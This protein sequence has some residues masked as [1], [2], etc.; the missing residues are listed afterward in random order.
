M[1]MVHFAFIEIAVTNRTYFCEMKIACILYRRVFNL[2]LL[3]SVRRQPV[4]TRVNDRSKMAGKWQG[5][6]GSGGAWSAGKAWPR[7]GGA[8]ILVRVCC[9][10]SRRKERSARLLLPEEDLP[11]AG[12]ACQHVTGRLSTDEWRQ[13]LLLL[14]DDVILIT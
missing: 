2:C 6:A 11:A 8:T 12:I 9:P 5:P 10:S 13:I 7:P 14:I 1:I 4:Q 3:V